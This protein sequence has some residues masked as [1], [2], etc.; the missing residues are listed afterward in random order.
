MKIYSLYSKSLERYSLPFFANDDDEAIAY[1]SRMVTTQQ[2]LSLVCSL[3]DLRL[4]HVGVFYPDDGFPCDRTCVSSVLDHLH[5]DL[6]LP[7]MI[8]ERIDKYYGGTKNVV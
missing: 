8:K 7:P 1:V 2:D 6:P 3:D 5:T 4:D